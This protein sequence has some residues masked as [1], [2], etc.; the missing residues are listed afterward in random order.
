M[1]IAERI[2]GVPMAAPETPVM[3]RL[4]CAVI[5]LASLSGLSVAG[6]DLLAW[7]VGRAAAGGILLV[8]LT[9]TAA[10]ATMFFCRKNRTDDAWL[11]DRGFDREEEGA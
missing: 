5:A 11:M 9:A 6:I 3:R 4:R 1:K 10:L 8:M 7:F 2:F